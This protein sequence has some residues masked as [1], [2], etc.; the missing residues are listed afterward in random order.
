M[1]TEN[2]DKSVTMLI[3]VLGALDPP[4]GVFPFAFVVIASFP[5]LSLEASL[6]FGS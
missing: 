5:R 2:P 6:I 3:W 1:K 4:L